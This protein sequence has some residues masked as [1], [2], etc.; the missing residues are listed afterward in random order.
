MR[1]IDTRTLHRDSRQH[2]KKKKTNKFI[3][4]FVVRENVQQLYT[5]VS[6]RL[7]ISRMRIVN[8]HE[9]HRWLELR[10]HKNAVKKRLTTNPVWG[11]IFDQFSTQ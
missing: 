4:F 5:H 8:F 2:E 3:I 1:I 9:K 6:A 11:P 7:W 10:S